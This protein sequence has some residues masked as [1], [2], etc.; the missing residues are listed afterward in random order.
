[1][2]YKAQVAVCSEI[3][4]KHVNAMWAPRRIFE[5]WIWWYV[6]LPLGFKR[7]GEDHP[8]RNRSQIMRR[9]IFRSVGEEVRAGERKVLKMYLPWNVSSSRNMFCALVPVH[10]Y[11]VG[12]FFPILSTYVNGLNPVPC[13]KT[14]GYTKSRDYFH[15]NSLQ[16]LKDST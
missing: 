8:F 4:T 6:K 10:A 14:S 12:P 13:W 15:D 1:M 7:L 2:F 16:R 9:R 3:R 5:C 11:C